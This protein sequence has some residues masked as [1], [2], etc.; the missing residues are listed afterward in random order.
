MADKKTYTV[1]RAMHGDGR[2]YARGDTREMT[3]ADAA[4]L[5]TTG[6]LSL[7]GDEPKAAAPAIEHTFG[8]KPS[9]VNDGGYTSASGGAVKPASK[10]ANKGAK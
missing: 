8:Q 3:E 9:S 7:E 5:V 1:H 2:D 4:S 10:P 6:A